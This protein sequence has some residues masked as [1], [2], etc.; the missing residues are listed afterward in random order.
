MVY[1]WTEFMVT[2]CIFV[3]FC[4]LL[5]DVLKKIVALVNVLTLKIKKNAVSDS[6]LTV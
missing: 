4:V 1:L 5:E 3:D 2:P 6:P